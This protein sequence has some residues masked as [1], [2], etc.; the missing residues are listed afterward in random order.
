MLAPPAFIHAYHGTAIHYCYGQHMSAS[1]DKAFAAIVGVEG[2][3]VNNP[4]DP[5]GETKFGISKRAYPKVDIKN[6]TMAQA[7]DIYANDYWVPVRGDDMP[8]PLSLFL[9]DAAVNQGI[10]AAIPLLQKS[11][12]VPQDGTLGPKTVQAAQKADPKELCS[13]FMANRA[14]RYTG[15]RNFDIDGRGW[16]KRLFR[17]VIDAT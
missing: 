17:V 15:T 16:L 14:L 6:L 9:F 13:L 5:G 7:K 8:W 1:F 4:T 3:Y 10:D 12:G 11:V 2:G